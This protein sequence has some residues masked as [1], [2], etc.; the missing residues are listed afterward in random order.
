LNDF[1][2]L[3]LPLVIVSTQPAP[4]MHVII[5]F[6][7]WDATVSYRGKAGRYASVSFANPGGS[8]TLLRGNIEWIAPF[9]FSPHGKIPLFTKTETALYASPRQGP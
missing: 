7:H 3:T 6:I 8:F 9:H 2:F 5:D 1:S 4:N